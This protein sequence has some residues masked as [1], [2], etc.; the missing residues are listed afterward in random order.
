M[1]TIGNKNAYALASRFYMEV[2]GTSKSNIEDSLGND[3]SNFIQ[4]Q[5]IVVQQRQWGSGAETFGY[6]TYRHVTINELLDVPLLDIDLSSASTGYVC[7]GLQNSSIR[8]IRLSYFV[9]LGFILCILVLSC[10]EREIAIFSI[11]SLF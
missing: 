4:H 7:L 3:S 1:H 10:L 5:R 11:L 6:S 2:M 8:I 9:Q